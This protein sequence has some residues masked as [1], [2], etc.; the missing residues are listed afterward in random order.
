MNCSSPLLSP[1]LR[2]LAVI[3][4]EEIESLLP[5]ITQWM[6]HVVFSC[7]M[8]FVSFSSFPNCLFVGDKKRVEFG[9]HLAC[10]TE[11]RTGHSENKE[12]EKGMNIAVLY[13]DAR[14]FSLSL[15]FYSILQFFSPEFLLSPVVFFCDSLVL[16]FL[17]YLLHFLNSLSSAFFNS[18]P[19][20]YTLN[21]DTGLFE[22]DWQT[23]RFN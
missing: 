8:M 1:M 5:G 13:C 20:Q 11:H 9:E 3:T 19:S 18:F 23:L 7:V 2:A 22:R 12:E 15:V 21:F 17:C 10:I 6:S 16:F 14:S 4:S